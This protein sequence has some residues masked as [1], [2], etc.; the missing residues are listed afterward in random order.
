MTGSEQQRLLWFLNLRY[1]EPTNCH[2]NFPFRLFTCLT[3]DRLQRW[4]ECHCL[5]WEAAGDV[6]AGMQI[7]RWV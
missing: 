6:D 1:Y 4:T 7:H 5:C 3:L 2:C